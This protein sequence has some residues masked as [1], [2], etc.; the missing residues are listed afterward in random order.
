MLSRRALLQSAAMALVTMLYLART[1][2]A[3]DAWPHV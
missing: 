1:A 3:E 2:V